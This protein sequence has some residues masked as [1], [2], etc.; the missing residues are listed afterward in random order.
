MARPEVTGKRWLRK[1]AVA[2]RYDCHERTID[3]MAADGRL[4]E[5]YYHGTRIPR[6]DEDELDEADRRATR[7]IPVTPG[8][9]A[10]DEKERARREATASN[11]KRATAR[12]GVF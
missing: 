4:P 10:R 12:D 6:W 2:L 3:A 7:D 8:T 9:V 1:K 11:D 5:P